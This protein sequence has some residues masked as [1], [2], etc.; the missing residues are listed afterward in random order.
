MD[1]IVWGGGDGSYGTYRARK[2]FEWIVR[3]VQHR[4]ARIPGIF[5]G[6]TRRLWQNFFRM[7]FV[8]GIAG[9]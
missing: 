4:P 1:L 8:T 3:S 9:E 5:N 7:V 6:L 2:V